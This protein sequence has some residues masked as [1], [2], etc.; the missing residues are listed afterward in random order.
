M[1]VKASNWL[2]GSST[3][4][5]TAS[6]MPTTWAVWPGETAGPDATPATPLPTRAGVFG[7]TRTTGCPA[8]SDSASRA[9]VTPAATETMR[10]SGDRWGARSASASATQ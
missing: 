6:I 8:G 3:Q 4:I 1:A 2:S 7:M 9:S 10:V 5:P